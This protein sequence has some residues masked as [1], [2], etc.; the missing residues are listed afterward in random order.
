M[1]TEVQITVYA[2]EG[3]IILIFIIDEK[4]HLVKNPFVWPILGIIFLILG[5]IIFFFDLS[6]N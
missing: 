5:V 4:K 6:F 1:S 2:L 3:L